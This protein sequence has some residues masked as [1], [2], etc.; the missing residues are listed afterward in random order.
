[1][2][3]LFIKSF[4]TLGSAWPKFFPNSF[5]SFK[6]HIKVFC[7]FLFD[8]LGKGANIDIIFLQMGIQFYQNHLLKILSS[9]H[10]VFL[11]SL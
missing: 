4:L 5:R 1:M 10:C 6:I 7:S 8:F 9:M 11:E 3:S 2:K